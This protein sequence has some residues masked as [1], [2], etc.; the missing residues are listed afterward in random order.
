MPE[1][2]TTIPRPATYG[3][4]HW[5]RVVVPS[6]R[7]PLMVKLFHNSEDRESPEYGPYVFVQTIAGVMRGILVQD[8]RREEVVAV[9]DASTG[10]WR[11]QDRQWYTDVV[12]WAAPLAKRRCSGSALRHTDGEERYGS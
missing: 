6:D 7:A 8:P 2:V 1:T 4:S 10:M 3:T 12:T 9:H 11:A 5:L